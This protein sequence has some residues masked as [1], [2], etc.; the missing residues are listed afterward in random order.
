MSAQATCEVCWDCSDCKRINTALSMIVHT[1][2]AH[3]CAAL[4]LPGY[5]RLVYVSCNPVTQKRDID[6]LCNGGEFSMLYVQGVDMFPQTVHVEN[7][8]VLQRRSE[9]ST[10]PETALTLDAL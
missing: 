4:Q 7:I 9:H 3:M 10:T 8:V 1:R 5:Q 6:F 2:C